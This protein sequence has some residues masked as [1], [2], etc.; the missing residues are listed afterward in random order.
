M[1]RLSISIPSIVSL[2]NEVFSAII[3]TNFVYLTET[4]LLIY[5]TDSKS[6]VKIVRLSSLSKIGLIADGNADAFIRTNLK[7]VKW[8]TLVSE[9]I[10]MEA[11]ALHSVI[12]MDN[13]L[14]R[15]NQLLLGTGILMLRVRQNY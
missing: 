5:V 6:F 8:D 7:A 10:L 4:E 14:T 3:S 13:C 9:V 1:V 2:D 15:Q 12:L 11:R